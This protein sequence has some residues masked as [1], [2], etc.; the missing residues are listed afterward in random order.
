M[1]RAT[2]ERPVCVTM[3]QLDGLVLA[4]SGFNHSVNF[5]SVMVLGTAHLVTDAAEAETALAAFVD[6]LYPGR[7]ATL[8]PMTAKERKATT[9]CGGPRGGIAKIRDDVCHDVPGDEAWRSGRL[10]PSGRPPARA[11][12][13]RRF[14]RHACPGGRVRGRDRQ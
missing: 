11:S 10:I 1:L 13:T 14:P 12:R 2:D 7:W 3:T 5:R 8:R 4:R 9:S 6:H